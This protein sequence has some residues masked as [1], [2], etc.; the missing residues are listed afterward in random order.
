MVRLAHCLLLM[1]M[2]Q[3][4]FGCSG[5][6][7][8]SS[9]TLVLALSNTNGNFKVIEYEVRK[10]PFVKS[11]QQGR[12]QLHLFGPDDEVLQKINFEK[13][14]LPLMEGQNKAID[15][16]VS[17]PLLAAAQRLEIYELDG[18]SGHYQLKTED[19]LLN[20]SISEDIK[21]QIAS[22]TK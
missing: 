9:Q 4:L 15:F 13:V 22:E 20:W 5:K 12:F 14:D 21:K 3:F 11:Q 1:S 7:Q 6:E 10:N 18:R 19:P 2:L 17:L 16:Y 8:V